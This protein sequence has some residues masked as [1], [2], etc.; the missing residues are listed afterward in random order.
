M[1]EAYL[2]QLPKETIGHNSIVWL[3]FFVRLYDKWERAKKLHQIGIH[4]HGDEVFYARAWYIIVTVKFLW[5][6][7]WS[8][9]SQWRGN[10]RAVI[11][12]LHISIALSVVGVI[13]FSLILAFPTFSTIDHSVGYTLLSLGLLAVSL[14]ISLLLHKRYGWQSVA[15]LLISALVFVCLHYISKW[16]LML[17]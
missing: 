11:S 8:L 13:L 4:L 14:Q 1:E 3:S 7:G 12:L 6:D 10:P 15:M 17:S 2:A 5:Q 16:F 9:L